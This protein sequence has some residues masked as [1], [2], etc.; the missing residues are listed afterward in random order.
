MNRSMGMRWAAALVAAGLV[1]GAAGAAD[2]P[3]NIIKYRQSVMKSVGANITSL[4]MVAKGEI[5]TLANVAA[6]AQAIRAGLSAADTLFPDGTGSEAGKTRSLPTVWERSDEFAAAMEKS[7]AAADDMIVAANS[8]DL[9]QIQTALGVLGKTCG[10]CHA[11]RARQDLRGL[12]RHL[13]R[14]AAIASPSRRWPSPLAAAGARAGNGEADAVAP[15]RLSGARRGLHSLP[16][17]FWKGGGAPLAGGGGAVESPFRGLLRPQSDAP[18][19]TRAGAAGARA[20][21]VRAMSFGIGPTGA[22]Y[23]PAFPYPAYSGVARADLA[24]MW[25]YLRSLA[26]VD[27]ADRAH[28]LDFPL[29]PFRPLALGLAVPVLRAEALDA[30]REPRRQLEPRRLSVAPPCCIAANATPA[31]T[32]SADSSQG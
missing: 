13:P 23:Y 28:E 11:R 16:H 30:G 1:A 8:G 15:R 26:P 5:S 21:F 9:G 14:K 4:A 19:R 29:P 22:P 25:R 31:A 12:P 10:G 2:E 32:L 7:A 20:D 6:N 18:P 27:R 17:R 3:A 24:D